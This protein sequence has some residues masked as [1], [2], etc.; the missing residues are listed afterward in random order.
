MEKIR[1]DKWLWAIRLYKTRTA[2]TT[3][4]EAGKVKKEEDK[5]KAASKIS[6]GDK[7]LVRH[8]HINRIL[9]VKKLI[10]KRVGAAI[11]QECYEDLTPPEELE[12]PKFKSAFLLPN[13]HREKGTGRP[14]KRDRRDIDKFTDLDDLDDLD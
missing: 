13:A 7:L 12:I 5:L 1:V 11:A 6:V 4:C 8:N 2:S 10:E 3:A 14:T 9:L